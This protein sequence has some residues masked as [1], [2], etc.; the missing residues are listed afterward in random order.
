MKSKFLRMSAFMTAF[1]L[2]VNLGFSQ[3][4]EVLGPTLHEQ[5]SGFDW[6]SYPSK[7]YAQK[8]SDAATKGKTVEVADDFTVPTVKP[9]T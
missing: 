2:V 4:Y 8:Y 1:L 7:Y 5:L 9:G 6:S 3:S